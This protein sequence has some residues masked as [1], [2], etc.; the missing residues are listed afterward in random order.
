MRV[1]ELIDREELK[2]KIREE[3]PDLADRVRI[4]SIVNEM[5]TVNTDHDADA[6]QEMY[7]RIEKERDLYRETLFKILNFLFKDREDEV[8]W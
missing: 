4:N 5:P 3:Y 2:S 6:L 1:L 8:P 7:Y